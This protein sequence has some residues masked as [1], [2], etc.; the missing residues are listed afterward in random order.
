ML[1]ITPL[2]DKCVDKLWIT[3]CCKC[4]NTKEKVLFVLP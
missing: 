4:L 2:V 1:W 3:P